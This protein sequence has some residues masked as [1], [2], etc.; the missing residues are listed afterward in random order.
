MTNETASFNLTAPNFASSGKTF[1]R[2]R[3]ST[4]PDLAPTGQ[5]PDGEVEDYIVILEANSTP[6][7]R[8]DSIV[9]LKGNLPRFPSG[10]LLANDTDPDGG[11]LTITSVTP[12][13]PSGAHVRRD[14]GWVIYEPP[15]GYNLPDTF[16][17]VVRN[18]RGATAMEPSL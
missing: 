18:G 9:R 10:E 4:Q 8:P 14:N 3:F 11:S 12:L 13:L 2:F 17:Y 15:A 16:N 1:A 6:I 7:A 5:A